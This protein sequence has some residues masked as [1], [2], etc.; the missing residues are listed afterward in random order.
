[1]KNRLVLLGAGASVEAGV[2]ASFDMTRKVVEAIGGRARGNVGQA[3]HFVCGALVAYD[4]AR[5]ASPY[6][7]LDVERVFAAVELLAERGDLE[8]TPFVAS[9]HPAVNSWDRPEIPSSFDRRFQKALE[10]NRPGQPVEDLLVRLVRSVTG[11][12]TGGTYRA[13]ADEMITQLQ[14]LV[15]IEEGREHYLQPLVSAGLAES[16]LTIASLNYDLAIEQ[17]SRRN[18]VSIET[19]IEGWVSD[20]AW[21]WPT[22]GIRLLKLHGSIDWRWHSEGRPRPGHLPRASVEV[23]EDPVSDRRRPVLVF[24]QRGKLRAEGPFLSLLVEFEQQL[25]VCDELVVVGYSFRDAHINEAI[26]H[27]SGENSERR[28]VIVDPRW[29]RLHW[30]DFRS[31]LVASLNARGMARRVEIIKAGAGEALPRLFPEPGAPGIPI[32]GFVPGP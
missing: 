14:V 5:G 10:T 9:W 30:N 15:S 21:R 29:E 19:G 31:Q 22:S 27:W 2:P 26:R 3:L 8:V 6:S 4:S 23:T 32:D 13:L 1:M 28:I 24:G 25:A 16:G 18:G 11:E 17:L 12:G 20:R 7:G